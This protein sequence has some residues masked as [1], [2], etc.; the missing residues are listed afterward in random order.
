[1]L[2]GKKILPTKILVKRIE[3]TAK[4]TQA[5]LIIPDVAEEVTSLG[6]VVLVGSTVAKLDEPIKVGHKVMHPPR[7]IQRVKTDE[8][9]YFLLNYTDIL[10]YW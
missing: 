8:G 7:A 6:E 2:D 9:D 1:M 10:L 4:T 5:G 3:R